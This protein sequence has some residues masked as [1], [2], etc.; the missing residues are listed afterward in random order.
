MKKS[1]K[2]INEKFKYAVKR[3]SGEAYLIMKQNPEINFSNEIIRSV[4]TTNA[5]DAQSE[6]TREKYYYDLI[7]ISGNK[8]AL[9]SRIINV[10]S[11]NLKDVW[12]IEQLFRLCAFFAK[13]G[14]KYAS[15]TVYE[16]FYKIKVSDTP[17]LGEEAIIYMDG[18]KGI[19]FLVEY[20]GKIIKNDPN[21][22]INTGFLYYLAQ[23]RRSNYLLKLKEYSK[24][25]I[26]V[27]VFLERS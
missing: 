11:K 15:S 8:E 17:W 22:Y 26:Y 9:I 21:E 5:F 16:Q 12:A 23:S 10:L 13:D 24:Q 27:K 14:N 2:T 4:I 18:F 20:Y 1:E 25:N 6:G 7:S 3:G 19:L